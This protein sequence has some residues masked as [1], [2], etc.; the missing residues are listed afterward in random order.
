MSTTISHVLRYENTDIAHVHAMLADPSF[1]ERVCEAQRVQRHE[2]SIEQERDG[3][4]VRVDQVQQASGIPGFARKFVGDEINIVQ[5]ER[6]SSTSQAELSVE[7]PGKPGE[8]TGTVTLSE[9]AG[10]VDETVQVTVK[11]A[12]PLVGGKIEKLIAELLL[13]ALRAE[14]RV[15][16]D[17][18]SA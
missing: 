9:S 10:G 5:Q 13:K 14:N 1:R 18:L 17:W 2:V 12:I 16:S 4:L 15:G 11:V 6:W 3:M 7:I 8:M